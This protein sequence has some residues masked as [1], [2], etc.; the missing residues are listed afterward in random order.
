MRS[1][2][3]VKFKPLYSRYAL[4]MNADRAAYLL[5]VTPSNDRSEMRR[6]PARFSLSASSDE[7][8]NLIFPSLQVTNSTPLNILLKNFLVVAT[9]LIAFGVAAP[10]PVPLQ[11]REAEPAN[12]YGQ[13]HNLKMADDSFK[14]REVEAVDIYGQ[15]HTLKI[16]DDSFKKRGAEPQNNIYGSAHRLKMADDAFKA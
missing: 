10:V 9:G 2:T 5:P 13:A 6:S 8:E 15:A 7:S 11:S 14:K 1:K 3:P 12:I 16:A 4:A